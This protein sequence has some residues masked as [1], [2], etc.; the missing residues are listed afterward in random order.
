MLPR[1][2]HNQRLSNISTTAT[3]NKQNGTY[4]DPILHGCLIS[5]NTIPPNLNIPG[6]QE[7]RLPRVYPELQVFLAVA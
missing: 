7:P 3:T 5:P 2:L 6:R 1:S 4:P